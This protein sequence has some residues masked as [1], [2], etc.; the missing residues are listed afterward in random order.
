MQIIKAKNYSEMSK[1][2][3]Q[4]IVDEIS[5]NPKLNICLPTG[6]TPKGLYKELVKANKNKKVNFSQ[7][8]FFNLDEYYPIKNTKDSYSNYLHKNLLD[9]INAKSENINFLDAKTQNPK[10]EC[11]DYETKLKKN[12][13]DLAI[14]GIGKN[15]HIAFNEPGSQKNSRTRLINLSKSTIKANSKFFKNKK[16]IPTKAMTIGTKNIL[17][18]KKIILLANH[19]QKKEAISHLIDDKPSKNWPATFLKN[20]KNFTLILD[21]S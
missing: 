4:I 15:G 18:A 14:L 11:K 7:T 1:K 21:E 10:K 3:S 9:H 20:H 12:P 19:K 6:A 16:Q 5:K 13:I 17:S 8:K 2:A